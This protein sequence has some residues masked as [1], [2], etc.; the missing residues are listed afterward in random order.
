MRY[1]DFSPP[2]PVKEAG[3]YINHSALDDNNDMGN[4]GLLKMLVGVLTTCHTQYT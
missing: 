2:S 4:T 3:T 1:T